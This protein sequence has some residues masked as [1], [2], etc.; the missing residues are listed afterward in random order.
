[1]F[2]QFD[3]SIKIMFNNGY[4]DK[5]YTHGRV[6]LDLGLCLM[7]EN[8]QQQIVAVYLSITQMLTLARFQSRCRV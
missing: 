8:I 1:L 4:M 2:D 3:E 5:S 6:G 7:A